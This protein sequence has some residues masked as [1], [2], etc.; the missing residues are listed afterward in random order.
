[1]NDIEGVSVLLGLAL[2]GS[3]LFGA[4]ILLG[5]FLLIDRE[6]TIEKRR[7]WQ[8]LWKDETDASTQNLLRP[9][10]GLEEVLVRPA[11]GRAETDAE[12]L[13]RSSLDQKS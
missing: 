6:K 7:Y 2:W 5:L 9:A 8:E 13:L 12:L 1:M 4:P 10:A 11:V 3:A